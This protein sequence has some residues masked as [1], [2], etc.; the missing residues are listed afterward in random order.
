MGF[1]LI[2]LSTIFLSLF[3]PAAAPPADSLR[4]CLFS[5]F[6]LIWLRLRLTLASPDRFALSGAPGSG[7]ILV[8]DVCGIE[9]GVSALAGRAGHLRAVGR[10]AVE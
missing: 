10:A 1:L 3:L 9:E 5:A 6:K 2:L 4:E 7:G 8:T